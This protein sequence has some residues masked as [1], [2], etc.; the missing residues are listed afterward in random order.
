MI[1]STIAALLLFIAYQPLI[2][3]GESLFDDSFLHEIHF[4]KMDTLLINGEK[5]YQMV[6][7][8][9][10]G[11]NVD[12]VGI[13]DKGNISNNVP[14]KKLPFKI[15]TNKYVSGK[16]YDGI[17]EFTLHNNFQDPSL[18]REKLTYD[19][20]KHLGLI[21]LRTAFAKVYINGSYWGL[22]TIVEGK[23]ELFKQRFDHRDADAIES[24]DF[25]DM[26][27]ISNNP[28]DYNYD[29]SGSPY[30]VL[31]NGEATTA[32][33]R[34]A[35][36]IDKANNTAAAD[37]LSEVSTYLNLQDFFTYQAANVYLMNFDSYLGF[38]GN[39]IYMYDTTAMIWQVIPWDFNAS[40]NLWDD[41]NGTQYANAYPLYP[42]IITDG[43]IAEN[44][45]TVPELKNYYLS[46]MCDLVYEYADTTSINNRIDFLKSQIQDA[47]YA[48]WR[49]VYSNQDFEETTGY[50]RFNIDANEFEGLKTFFSERY[51]LIKQSLMDEG[52]SCTPTSVSNNIGH[53]ADIEIFPNP[54]TGYL[55]IKGDGPIQKLTVYDMR[56]RKLRQFSQPDSPLEIKDLKA[57]MYLISVLIN[58]QIT[59]TKIIVK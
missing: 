36:M 6:N 27:Y 43:C 15:K 22:Y 54:N 30:Y 7:M 13:K 37:Y 47:V 57:G 17:K 50:G 59:T 55:N 19:F 4:E 40:L 56:G 21:S 11:S 53:V 44:I 48:D 8:S 25:G 39:Q 42:T 5:T 58:H 10:D 18:L 3:Q 23:D 34:F 49:K 35:V 26:C 9:I 24:L 29:L 2:G 41:G 38:K 12:S 32:F 16:K 31:E 52:Y 46:A 14:N 20:C 1:K 28:D 33:Q 45:N 51:E